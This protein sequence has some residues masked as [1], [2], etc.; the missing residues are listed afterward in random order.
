MGKRLFTGSLRFKS[1]SPFKVKSF[2]IKKK[3][4][5]RIKA[6]KKIEASIRGRQWCTH[7]VKKGNFSISEGTI[8]NEQINKGS[9]TPI[10]VLER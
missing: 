2:Y 1:V 9:A 10:D 7:C 6:R 3:G 4:S 5:Q 8:L